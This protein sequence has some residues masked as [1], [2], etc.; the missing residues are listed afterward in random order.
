MMIWSTEEEMQ[1]VYDEVNNFC[2]VL[3]EKVEGS[4]HSDNESAPNLDDTDSE[5]KSDK[6]L[7]S[8]G[9][10]ADEKRHREYKVDVSVTSNLSRL[11]ITGQKLSGDSISLYR[12]RDL[13]SSN[14]SFEKKI[15]ASYE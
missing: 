5:E 10:D 1:K 13:V 12:K 11:P 15:K 4:A 14:S 6:I 9:A 3:K 7:V 8:P 2:Q